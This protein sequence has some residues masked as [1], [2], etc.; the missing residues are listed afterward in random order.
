MEN[1]LNKY[2]LERFND[3]ISV[4]EY[5]EKYVNVNEFLECCKACPCYGTV[6]SCPPYDFDPVEDYWK[7]HK[8]LEVHGYK[9]NFKPDVT[10]DE[11][12]KI[13]QRV[14]ALMSKEM[15]AKEAEIPARSLC[16]PETARCAAAETAAGVKESLADSQG[17]CAIPLNRSAAMWVRRSMIFWDATL[18]GWRKAKFHPIIFLWEACLKDEESF[19][20]NKR[21]C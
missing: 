16:P 8:T 11:S 9:I 21:Y 14:K 12:Q 20:A 17:I 4:E 2:E 3:E 5:L 6:W 10:V 1:Y 18:N 7:K 19:I 13:M 15:F